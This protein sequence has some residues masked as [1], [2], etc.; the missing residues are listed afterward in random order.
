VIIEYFWYDVQA[1]GR[2]FLDWIDNTNYNTELI[3]KNEQNTLFSN[4]K[5]LNLRMKIKTFNQ[6]ILIIALILYF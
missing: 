6:M 3:F 4:Y 5:S 2:W 1:N